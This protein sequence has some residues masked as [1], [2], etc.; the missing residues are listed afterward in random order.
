MTRNVGRRGAADGVLS[1]PG[2]ARPHEPARRT[3]SPGATS[4]ATCGA[5]GSGCCWTSA[6]GC[7]VEPRG[8][9]RDRGGGAR[10]SRRPGAI[11]EPMAPFLTRDM[12]D[13]L[14]R[15]WRM[16]AWADI[17]RAG[18]GAARAGAALHPRLGGGGARGSRRARLFTR[19][20]PDHGCDAQGRGRGL[21]A[22][23]LRAVAHRADA[24][25]SRPSCLARPN[26]PERPF[27]H[28]GFTVAVQHV[29]AAGGSI[30]CGYTAA[31]AAD[32]A[33]DRRPALR[34]SR[35]AR[36]A[37]AFEEMRGE[38]RPWPI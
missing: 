13:G 28:I 6:A 25:P 10:C 3:R 2:R 35:R 21:P 5:C 22:L 17:S 15:F 31:R 12:L 14:D 16:R 19:L 23:R 8:A 34:R 37:A 24:R 11:V 20:Q 38:Q 26:D 9:R 18:A 32:R 33:A 4:T 7:R 30:N 29:R 36:L 27:E 1:P